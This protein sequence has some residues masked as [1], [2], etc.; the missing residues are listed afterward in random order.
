VKNLSVYGAVG[1]GVIIACFGCRKEK[2]IPPIKT[3]N[4]PQLLFSKTFGGDQE[5]HF[6]TIAVESFPGNGSTFWFTVPYN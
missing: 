4:T 2:I 3:D 5:E 1:L 6:G